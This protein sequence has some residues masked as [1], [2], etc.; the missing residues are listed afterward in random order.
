MLAAVVIAAALAVTG[1]VP[2][3]VRI[4]GGIASPV[5]VDHVRAV[6][7][8][9]GAAGSDQFPRYLA[10]LRTT[11]INA[12]VVDVKDANGRLAFRPESPSLSALAPAH[13]TISNL[14]DRVADIHANGG[15]AIARIP[16]FQDSWFA[17][18]TPT[19]AIRSTSGALWRDHIGQAWLDPAS[20]RVWNYAIDL[21]REA[22]AFGFD[23]VNFDYIRFPSDGTLAR[24]T[25]P[26][27]NRKTP[28]RA[29][30]AAFARAVDQGVR[31]Q[32]IRTSADLFGLVFW[33]KNDLGIG[34]YLEDLAPHFD[35][36][37]PMVY[38]SHYGKGFLGFANPAVEPFA[39]ISETLQKGRQRLQRLPKNDQ[40]AVRPWLQDFRMGAPYDAAMIREEMRAAADQ[41]SVGWMLWNPLS[42]YTDGAIALPSVAETIF[43]SFK[44]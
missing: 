3:P 12:L 9:S 2:M 8:T 27:W 30:I 28:R 23:E 14:R 37:A 41:G 31:A 11:T 43:R 19:E 20:E 32:G 36:L 34:Q 38:P 26:R 15:L 13:P 10:L 21:A 24:A 4:P 42:R 16:V 44:K 33:A 5:I 22:A 29:V 1:E 7:L 6:Y 39:V 17:E 35:V 25:Y 18:Q 40:P